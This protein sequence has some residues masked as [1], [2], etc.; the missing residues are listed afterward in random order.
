M[1]DE[2]V[3]S[4]RPVDVAGVVLVVVAG[5]LDFNHAEHARDVLLAA[6]AAPGC[7]QLRVDAAALEFIDACG[8]GALVAA[9]NATTAAG[10]TFALTNPAPQVRDV[11]Q[12]IGLGPTFGLAAA[13]GTPAAAR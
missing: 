11:V 7:R 2:F 12:M 5:A 3:I 4:T 1:A 6:A 9:A 13:D 8:L 10:A